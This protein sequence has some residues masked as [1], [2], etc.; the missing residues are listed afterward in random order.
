MN[1]PI[2]HRVA[3]LTD[4]RKS[5]RVYTHAVIVERD[6]DVLRA[7]HEEADVAK[8]RKNAGSFGYYGF[9]EADARGESRMVTGCARPWLYTP[10]ARTI[11]E[12]REFLAQF[13]TRESYMQHAEDNVRAAWAAKAGTK[14]RFVASWHQSLRGAQKGAADR[15]TTYRATKVEIVEVIRDEAKAA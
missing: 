4:T 13:P 11:A 10:D 15:N 7:Q 1:K 14:E 2:T 12:A 5:P 6:N 8:A 3:G 9:R